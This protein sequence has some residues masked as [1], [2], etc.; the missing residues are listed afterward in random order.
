MLGSLLLSTLMGVCY[1]LEPID[2]RVD[3]FYTQIYSADILNMGDSLTESYR[4]PYKNSI[5]LGIVL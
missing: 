3:C 1:K 5:M 2:I 4:I